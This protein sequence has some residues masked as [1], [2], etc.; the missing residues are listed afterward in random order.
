MASS[1]SS[2]HQ[3]FV[4]HLVARIHSDM[5]FLCSQG[6]LNAQDVEVIKAKL[7]SGLHGVGSGGVERLNGQLG[8]LDLNTHPS[9]RAQAGQGGGSTD[10]ATC[11][12]V[13]DYQASQPDD[14]PFTKGQIIVLESELNQDWWQGSID[15]R[16]GIF[17]SNHVER[18]PCD[19]S[20]TTTSNS[21]GPLPPPNSAHFTP[22]PSPAPYYNHQPPP[23]QT[24]AQQYAYQQPQPY[25]ASYAPSGS[26][27]YPSGP[28]QYAP[29]NN[30]YLDDKQHYTPPPPP[31]QIYQPP[32]PPPT[33]APTQAMGTTT[34]Q[35]PPMPKKRFGKVGGQ[36][37]SAFVGGLGFGTGS[38]VA[39]NAINAIL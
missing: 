33:A 7:P 38:A 31:Q 23:P 15:G 29:P 2:T 24:Q 18:L 21:N 9:E 10:R 36:L 1:T 34:P 8:G 14:L 22:S 30:P 32:P 4:D 27:S 13:W 17:P 12:A 3:A 6:L 35:P 37:G 39:S 5:D 16:K 20:S 19:P 28:S 26:N 11:R 25:A